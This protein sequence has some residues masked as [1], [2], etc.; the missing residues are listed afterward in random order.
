MRDLTLTQT[1]GRDAA[2]AFAGLRRIAANWLRRRRLRRV[3]DLDDHI[4]SDIGV[5]RDELRAALKLPLSVDPIWELNSQAR[6]RRSR[7]GTRWG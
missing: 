2:G 7:Q 1:I 6:R 3:D 4:L 5:T